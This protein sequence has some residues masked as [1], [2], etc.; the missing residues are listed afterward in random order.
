MNRLPRLKA[1][2][3]IA[4][5]ALLAACG[6]PT[7]ADLVKKAQGADTKAKLES[8]LGKPTELSKVG[9]VEKWTYKAKDGA[10]VFIITGETVAIQAAN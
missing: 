2:G 10:V 3:A 1:L 6:D 9:P 7:K 5:L 8:V 4:V